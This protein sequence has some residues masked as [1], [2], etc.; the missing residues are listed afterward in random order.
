MQDDAEK[1]FAGLIRQALGA[2]RLSARAAALHAGLPVR[3]I[4]GVLE[5]HSPSLGRVA[6]ICAALKIQ[7]CIGLVWERPNWGPLAISA[8]LPQRIQERLEKLAADYEDWPDARRQDFMERFVDAMTGLLDPWPY[9][10][11]R[12]SPPSPQRREETT[13]LLEQVRRDASA[14]DSSEDSA[15]NAATEGQRE[16]AAKRLAAVERSNALAREGTP[17]LD[18]DRAAAAEAGVTPG[19][20]GDW[21]RKVKDLPEDEHRV[22]LLGRKRTGRPS[23]FD[24]P[25]EETLK[26]IFLQNPSHL[27]GEH[28]RNILIERHGKA[29]ALSTVQHRLKRERDEFARRPTLP[30]EQLPADVAA[31]PGREP[32]TAAHAA[33]DHEG[34][35]PAIAAAET[36]LDALGL[37]LSPDEKARLVITIRNVLYKERGDAGAENATGSSHG[38]A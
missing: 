29:P 30:A 3:S 37:A 23:A 19:A 15:W 6:E 21:R 28:V 35:R 2:H 1:R 12:T 32:V 5:G 18:A 13:E 22:A 38:V 25:M 31:L 4:Q 9:E 17:R 27:T 10:D 11:E 36:I 26:E 16:Q 14:G 7:F 24:G 20:V 34:L 8:D 33:A